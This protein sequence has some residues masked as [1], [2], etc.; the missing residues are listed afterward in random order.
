MN[1]LDIKDMEWE[2]DKKG[3]FVWSATNGNKCYLL[4]Y[5]IELEKEIERLKGG[6][7]HIKKHMENIGGDSVVLSG[8]YNMVLMFLNQESKV[9]D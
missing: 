6:Y 3:Q 7:G 9:E 1:K 4:D 2:Q 8:T 5:A